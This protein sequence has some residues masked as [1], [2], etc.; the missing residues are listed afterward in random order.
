MV[1]G[2]KPAVVGAAQRLERSAFDH[3]ISP[4]SRFR[5]CTALRW[6]PAYRSQIETIE[7]RRFSKSSL[8]AHLPDLEAW[9]IFG[10]VAEV[11]SL[12]P[13]PNDLHFSHSPLS[14]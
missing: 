7:T 14:Q 2:F 13:P 5:P 9:A 12:V 6:C 1:L 4:K 3:F 11:G 8:M 10:K